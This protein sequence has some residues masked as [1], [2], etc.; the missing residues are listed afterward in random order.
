MQYS[1]RPSH[2]LML[3]CCV[4]QKVASEVSAPPPSTLARDR[5]HITVHSV[6]RWKYRTSE[7]AVAQSFFF[8][9][10]RMYVWKLDKF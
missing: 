3:I 8:S 2:F 10:F 1:S 7:N 6:S 9:L 5:L 4:K